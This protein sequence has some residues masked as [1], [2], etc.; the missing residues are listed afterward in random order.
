[1]IRTPAPLLSEPEEPAPPAS[2]GVG[3]FGEGAPDICE[4]HNSLWR[5]NDDLGQAETAQRMLVM[6]EEQAGILSCAPLQEAM[7]FV[8]AEADLKVARLRREQA[9]LEERERARG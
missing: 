9:D 7:R 3:L 5:I 4:Y 1:M 8:R 2:L 6:W